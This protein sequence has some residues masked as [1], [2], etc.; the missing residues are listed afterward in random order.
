MSPARSK[1]TAVP[2]R[3]SRADT[4]KAVGVGVG[5]VVVTA[6]LVWLL[7]PGS[8]GS[9]GTGG[10]ANRQ[11]RMGWLFLIGFGLAGLVVW[12]VLGG[13]RRFKGREKIALP[14]LLGM[15]ALGVVIGAIVW[16][17]GV[18]RHE[19]SLPKP[20][21]PGTATTTPTSPS[22]PA[23]TPTS[24]TASTTIPVTTTTSA[25]STGASTTSSP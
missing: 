24:G 13:S 19:Q 25:T 7:R 11:P 14:I 3:R 1:R 21:N 10:L 4:I 15:V 16:P 22:T 6:V 8:A 23:S 18:L 12:A 17:G 2:N 9:P 20:I 5:I